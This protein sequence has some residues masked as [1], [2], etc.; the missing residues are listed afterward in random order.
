MWEC[1][2][3][4]ESVDYKLL[5]LRFLRKIW[6]VAV[7]AV[8]GCVLVAGLYYMAKIIQAGGR[9][10]QADSLFYLKLGQ[11]G[12]GKEYDYYNY[13][14]WN[15]IIDSDFLVD[16]IYVKFEGRLTKDEIRDAVSASVDFDPRY[17]IVSCRTHSGELS[18]ELAKTVEPLV[19]AFV[20]T[21]KE[22]ESVEITKSAE[23]AKD[24]TDIRMFNACG[25]GFSLGIFFSVLGILIALTLDTSVYL[26]VTLER[27]Y[28]LVTLGAPFMSEF[29]SNLEHML[30]KAK[31]IAVVYTDTPVPVEEMDGLPVV[32]CENPVEKPEELEK[33][34][35]CDAVVLCVKAAGKNGKRVERCLEQLARQEIAVTATV[36]VEADEKLI[37]AY[38]GRKK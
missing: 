38:Y 1:E 12:T 11:D 25:L 20:D 19:T 10:Y 23:E 21:R 36:L 24:S 33:I 6:I 22:F 15:E 34:R 26:P 35:E 2:Y 4:K 17:L 31:K 3:A 28:H 16:E 8:I 13:Y 37:G 7:S 30:G 18:L 5:G 14:T 29:A 32:I 9:V 27:R